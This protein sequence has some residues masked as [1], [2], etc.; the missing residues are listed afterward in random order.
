MITAKLQSYFLKLENILEPSFIDPKLRPNP[1]I[2]I[3]RRLFW[4][5]LQMDRG[6]WLAGAAGQ[7]EIRT[8]DWITLTYLPIF[9][10]SAKNKRRYLAALEHPHY[11]QFCDSCQAHKPAAF[12]FSPICCDDCYLP[13]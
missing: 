10:S 9:S 2:R 8:S 6:R 3:K 5:D 7:S 11:F 13:V 1:Y 12:M 4:S